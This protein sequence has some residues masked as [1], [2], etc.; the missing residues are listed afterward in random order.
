MIGR[1]EALFFSNVLDNTRSRV[2]MDKILECRKNGT[3]EQLKREFPDQ[4][5]HA[6]ALKKHFDLWPQVEV[7]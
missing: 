1:E 4:A 3:W 6:D 2:E 5:D 7:R